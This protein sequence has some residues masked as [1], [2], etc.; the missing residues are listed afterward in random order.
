MLDVCYFQALPDQ[1]LNTYASTIH[2]NTELIEALYELFEEELQQEVTSDLK[3][4]YEREH[5]MRFI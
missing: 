1:E 2:N 4:L 5:N 3:L